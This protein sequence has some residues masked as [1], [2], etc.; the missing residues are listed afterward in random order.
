MKKAIS[1]KQLAANRNNALKS[2]GPKT[3]EGKAASKMNA[4]KHG[5]CSREVLVHGV[6]ITES[7]RELE[8]LYERFWEDL[9]PVGPM[10]E[11][12]V[13]EIVTAYWRK[14]RA[15]KAE[16]GEIALSVDQ[17]QLRRSNHNTKF[18]VLQWGLTGDVISAMHQSALG[19]SVQANWLRELRAQLERTGELTGEDLKKFIFE[20]QRSPIAMEMEKLRVKFSQ[21]AD[22]VDPASWR[23]ETKREALAY[24][25][26]QLA[27]RGFS[28]AVCEKREKVEEESRQA[29]AVLPETEILDKILRYE[30]KLER[31]M[32]RAMSQ[33]E[34]LQRIRRG[35]TVPPPLGMEV[36]HRD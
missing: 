29:A 16:S 9:N 30:A 8:S 13:D 28:Q 15:L 7:R 35:E 27:M 36:T 12:L 23:E 10:E 14:L 19:N 20:D 5:I 31:Q 18:Q 3:P 34:R 33:L 11:V 24:I 4:L 2:T 22:A 6:N 25:D 32:Y 21:A 17:G 26:R 1:S